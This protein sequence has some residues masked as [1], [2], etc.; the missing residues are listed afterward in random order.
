MASLLP[1]F[2]HFYLPKQHLSLDEGMIPT[3]KRLAI[4]QYIKDK[5][6]KWGIKSFLLCYIL[7]A[8]IYT[9]A[10]PMPIKKLGAVRNTVIRL[11]TSCAMENKSHVLVLDRFYNSVTL[12][13][14]ALSELHTGI[15]GTPAAKQEAVS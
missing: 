1:K 8:V 12:A 13:K 7:N 14:Y 2:L 9:G 15:E 6:T 3:K 5:P 10:V 4:K 11:L